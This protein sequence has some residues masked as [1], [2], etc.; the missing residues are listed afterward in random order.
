MRKLFGKSNN[1]KSKRNTAPVEAEKELLASNRSNS[2][3]VTKSPT[4]SEKSKKVEV[5]GYSL[6]Y[7]LGYAGRA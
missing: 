6:L 1:Q 2:T 5:F 4:T 7:L 3:P